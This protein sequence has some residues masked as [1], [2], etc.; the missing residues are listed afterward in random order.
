MQNGARRDL[1]GKVRGCLNASM[2]RPRPATT[3]KTPLRGAGKLPMGLAKFFAGHSFF[4]WHTPPHR[5]DWK[6][7]RICGNQNQKQHTEQR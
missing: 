6:Q 1:R 2:N 4:M 7:R 3:G 5:R